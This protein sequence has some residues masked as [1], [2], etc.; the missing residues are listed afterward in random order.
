MVSHGVP[1]HLHFALFFTCKFIY[2]GKNK[3]ELELVVSFA[4]V[5]WAVTL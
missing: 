4:A 2:S 3:L 1:R 5:L